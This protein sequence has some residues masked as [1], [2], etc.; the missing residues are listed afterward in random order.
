MLELTKVDRIQ[1]VK[2]FNAWLGALSPQL[3][4]LRLCY[5]GREEGEHPLA[6]MKSLD[7]KS[8]GQPNMRMPVLKELWLGRVRD[9]D[10]CHDLLEQFAPELRR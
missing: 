3:Q 9:V 6:L 5:L 1:T 2:M 4:S 8:R 10:D 7:I